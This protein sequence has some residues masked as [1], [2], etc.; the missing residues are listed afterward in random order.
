MQKYDNNNLLK[1][2]ISKYLAYE[3][4]IVELWELYI[5]FKIHISKQSRTGCRIKLERYLY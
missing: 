2:F 4:E 3:F 5:N 1:L